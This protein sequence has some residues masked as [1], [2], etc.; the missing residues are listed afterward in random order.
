M[1]DEYKVE[2]DI[3]KNKYQELKSKIKPKEYTI[4]KEKKKI[5]YNQY[6]LASRSL[7][8]YMLK[9]EKIIAKVEKE[10]TFFP[11]N[12]IRTLANELIYYYHKYGIFKIADFISYIS[13]NEE[14]VKIFNEIISMNINESYIL[15][16]IDDYIKVVNSYPIRKKETELKEQLKEE[17]DPIKQAK[18]LGEI[19]SLKG[20]KQ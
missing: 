10:I 12:N 13:G 5:K 18:I 15:E 14:M 2:Y 9:D 19:L 8:F 1:S 3:L 20:V 4:T 7:L 17:T 11:D 6:E 16:E